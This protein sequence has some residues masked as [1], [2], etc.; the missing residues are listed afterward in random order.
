MMDKYLADCKILNPG[1]GE[2]FSYSEVVA[3]APPLRQGRSRSCAELS[4]HPARYILF[5]TDGGVTHIVTSK[6]L[7]LLKPEEVL[8]AWK[9]A[10]MPRALEV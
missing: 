7:Y 4:G 2:V 9:K 6:A 3:S 10:Q 1:T 5:W 8:K